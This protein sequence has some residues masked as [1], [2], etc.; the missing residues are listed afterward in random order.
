MEPPPLITFHSD[1]AAEIVDLVLI[2]C[3][4]GIIAILVVG[5][6][7]AAP[8]ARR[9]DRKSMVGM[10]LQFAGYATCFAAFRPIFSP[11]FLMSKVSA[12]G[13]AVFTVALAL[14]STWF[15]YAAA[16]ALGRHWALMARVIDGHELVRTGPYA[17]VRNPIYLAMMGLVIATGLAFSRWQAI[18][19][20]LVVYLIGTLV[21]IRAEEEL[22]RDAFRARFDDYCRSVPALVPRL[23]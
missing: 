5:K 21:R 9:S 2:A 14:A 6:R 3:W 19:P 23:I 22:L 8:G 1:L 13:V 17:V 16:R 20:A 11:P 18:L 7:R 15:C 10:W 4:M 12:S